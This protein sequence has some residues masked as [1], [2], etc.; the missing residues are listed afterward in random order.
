MTT[1]ND[2]SGYGKE[3]ERNLRLKT[4]PLAL[5]ML[6]S[7]QEIPEGA[8]R[9]V[10][11]L[12][13]H[14]SLCQGFAMSRREGAILA[15]LK[16]D[17]WCFEP[18]VGYGLAEPPQHFL[19][20]Y[21]RYPMGAKTLEA[22]S[23]WARN[24]PRLETGKYV[25][26]VFAPLDT[27]TFEPDVILMYCH[28]AQLTQILIVVNWIDGYDVGSKLSGHAGCVYSGV[29]SINDR[30]FYVAIPC[31]GDRMFAAAQDDEL[32]F[33]V[34]RETIDEFIAGFQ[35]LEEFGFGGGT[36][37]FRTVMM[38][39]Y[40]LTEVYAKIGRMLGMEVREEGPSKDTI[41]ED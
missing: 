38:P 10:R 27:A 6:E 36:L 30:K 1:L 37:P 35:Y 40:G 26:L 3:L 20:G 5:R 28:P 15:M 21:N 14:L 19:E 18:V 39:E 8:V 29:P 33:T 31:I 41:T 24:M 7:V 11:D 2:L 4:R 34:P 23:I 12:G 16:E 17:M 9:P 13:H 32:V 25:G 22:G